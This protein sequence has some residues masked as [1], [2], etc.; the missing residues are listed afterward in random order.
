MYSGAGGGGVLISE[1]TS[2]D[3]TDDTGNDASDDTSDN[4]G[5]KV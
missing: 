1:E 2:N 5:G 4:D 3:A